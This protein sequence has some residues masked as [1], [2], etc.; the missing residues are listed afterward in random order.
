M[1]DISLIF[2]EKQEGRLCAQHCL[3]AVLQGS[4]FTAVDLSEIAMGLDEEERK[5]MSENEKGVESEDYKRFLQQPSG[6]MD[7]TGF[8]SVQVISKALVL[9]NLDL[10]P[11]NSK[12]NSIAT[13]IRAN[14]T[15]AQAYIFNMESHWYCIRRFK[16]DT[17]QR[18]PSNETYAYFNL[19]SLLSR[20]DYM[21]SSFLLEY[22]KQMQNEGYSIFVVSGDF[23]ESVSEPI[24]Y[25]PNSAPPTSST[26]FIDLTKSESKVSDDEDIQRAIKLSLD[27]YS[28]KY[29]RY[30]P[31]E[32]TEYKASSSGASTST[33]SNS[34]LDAALK[35]S[36]EC[37]GGSGQEL[38][39]TNKSETLTQNQLRDKR[40][41]YFSAM[42]SNDK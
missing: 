41:A 42:S 9:W 5:Q 10:I 12:T 32:A 38:S 8:F 6:N 24:K 4:Y 37:F 16:C 2:H 26:A 31:P 14:P 3:N 33:E 34:D 15:K 19:D 28:K 36:L 27:E 39:N 20:P 40:L 1:W 18:P 13:D 17:T 35:L 29:D 22:I 30:M 25:V 11:L 23:P 7:D 21:S